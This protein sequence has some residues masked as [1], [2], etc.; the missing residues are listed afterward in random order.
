M[1]ASASARAGTFR[2][3]VSPHRLELRILRE[4]VLRVTAS[5]QTSRGDDT[6]GWPGCPGLR[7]ISNAFASL[8]NSGELAQPPAVHYAPTV[9]DQTG[10]L[11]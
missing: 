1:V 9:S 6:D 3:A 5:Q 10:R 4:R 2:S 11:I 8:G 7:R